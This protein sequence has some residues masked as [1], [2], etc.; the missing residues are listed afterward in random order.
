MCYVPYT[1]KNH[2]P[3]VNAPCD[4]HVYVSLSHTHTTHTTGKRAPMAAR[5]QSIRILA[6]G[7]GG[8]ATGGKARGGGLGTD[9][10][11]WYCIYIYIYI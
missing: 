5:V 1:K 3:R 9:A 10:P 7:A 6:A 2:F 4:T 8:I 11:Y